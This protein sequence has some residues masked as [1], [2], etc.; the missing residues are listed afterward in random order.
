MAGAES[1]S[2]SANMAHQMSAYQGEPGKG[3]EVVAGLF[4][5][6]G[7]SG[8]ALDGDMTRLSGRIR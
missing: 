3:Q 4:E 7:L 2:K 6:D 8:G 5:E 1:Y